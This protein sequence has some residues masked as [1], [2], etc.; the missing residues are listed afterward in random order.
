LFFLHAVFL[1]G[2]DAQTISVSTICAPQTIN[3]NGIQNSKNSYSGA[4]FGNGFNL[5]I[6][7]IPILQDGLR[8]GGKAVLT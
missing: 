3:F 5:K 6:F 1:N 2:L 8:K 4:T 7:G